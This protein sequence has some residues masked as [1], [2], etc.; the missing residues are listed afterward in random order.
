MA[1]AGFASVTGEMGAVI[2]VIGFET[3]LSEPSIN[4]LLAQ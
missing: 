2:L 1:V 3:P 4:R